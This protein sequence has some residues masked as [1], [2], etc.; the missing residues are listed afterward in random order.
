MGLGHRPNPKSVKY[1][2]ARPV[3]TA[4][5]ATSERGRDRG[6]RVVRAAGQS[7]FDTMKV[8][9]RLM[10]PTAIAGSCVSPASTSC[11]R[12]G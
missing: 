6:G 5:K 9:D 12:S 7:G 4:G 3:L 11:G 2:R 10:P 8:L 1:L